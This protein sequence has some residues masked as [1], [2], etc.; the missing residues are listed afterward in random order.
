MFIKSQIVLL[1]ALSLG[2]ASVATATTKHSVPLRQ[3][4]IVRQGSPVI[5]GK[6]MYDSKC[7][8]DSV[9]PSGHGLSSSAYPSTLALDPAF[10]APQ[11]LQ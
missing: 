2:T 7:A 3:A 9:L 6:S 1:L 11:G 4:E 8:Y 10:I 5:Y